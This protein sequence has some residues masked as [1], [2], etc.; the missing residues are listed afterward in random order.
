MIG[1][2]RARRPARSRTAGGAEPDS[3]IGAGAAAISGSRVRGMVVAS[4]FWLFL[5]DDD[6]AGDLA[7][8]A[9]GVHGGQVGQRDALRDVDAQLAAVDQRRQLRELLG[10]AADEDTG[11]AYAAGLVARRRDRR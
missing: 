9:L 1:S 5:D 2:H 3:A 11:G 8:V 10:V 7:G 4:G 6:L